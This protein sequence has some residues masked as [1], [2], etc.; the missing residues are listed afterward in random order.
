M[1]ESAIIARTKYCS[2]SDA[3][4]QATLLLPKSYRRRPCCT[5]CDLY[6]S[7]FDL[8]PNGSVSALLLANGITTFDALFESYLWMQYLKAQRIAF[9]TDPFAVLDYKTD[10]ASSIST[11]CDDKRRWCFMYHNCA[12]LSTCGLL[13][14]V[15]R[16]RQSKAYNHSTP[17]ISISIVTMNYL[18]AIFRD[19]LGLVRRTSQIVA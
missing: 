6:K 14:T 5:C 11:G 1:S 8:S 12:L 18:S 19:D 7:F 10:I 13:Q 16:Y 2:Q 4:R 17:H 15:R 9:K 3:E